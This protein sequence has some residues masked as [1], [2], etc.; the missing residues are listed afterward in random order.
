[1]RASVPLTLIAGTCLIVVG[2]AAVPLDL[3]AQDVEM[4]G[5]IHGV[6]PPPAYYETL[7]RYPNAYQFE[8]VWKEI[9]RQV[10]ERRQALARAG[11]F[12]ALNAHFRSG[13]PSRATAQAAG[14]A[15]TG[16]FRFPVLVGY[17]SDSTHA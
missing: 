4:L 13:G 15:I 14:A 9:A 17:F 1:M 10:R 3:V 5:R 16:T 6:K 7:A 2:R 11:D 8:K 12:D